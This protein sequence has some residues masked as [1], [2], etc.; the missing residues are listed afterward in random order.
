M[1]NLAETHKIKKQKYIKLVWKESK[2]KFTEDSK[3]PWK[4]HEKT[5]KTCKKMPTKGLNSWFHWNWIGFWI[6]SQTRKHITFDFQKK[7]KNHLK[8][9]VHLCWIF[10]LIFCKM[11]NYYHN[12]DSWNDLK[13][14]E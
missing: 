1:Q 12:H 6:L 3:P 13:G 10:R 5:Y 14:V 11:K 2:W 9:H 8:H 4:D 7:M